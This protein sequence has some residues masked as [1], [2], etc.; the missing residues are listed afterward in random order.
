M[1]KTVDPDNFVGK[2]RQ[3][4]VKSQIY[5]DKNYVQTLMKEKRRHELEDLN[6]EFPQVNLKSKLDVIQKNLKMRKKIKRI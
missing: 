6:F 1:S 2:Y 3:E 5:L 4:R